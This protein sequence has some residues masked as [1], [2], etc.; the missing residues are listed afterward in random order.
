MPQNVVL[1]EAIQRLEHL[2]NLPGTPMRA[3]EVAALERII[4]SGAHAPKRKSARASKKEAL[5]DIDD[6]EDDETPSK[7]LKEVKN[8]GT[9]RRIVLRKDAV[10]ADL[11]EKEE[12]AFKKEHKQRIRDIK[13]TVGLIHRGFS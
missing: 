1:T 11:A 4:A 10:R 9:H 3:R 13:S 2:R 6:I 7:P 5:L 8:A 12:A